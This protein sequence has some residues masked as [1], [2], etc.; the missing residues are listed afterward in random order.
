MKIWAVIGALMSVLA[1]APPEAGAEPEHAEGG[2]RPGEPSGYS[3]AGP[4]FYV[5]DEDR[6]EAEA[7]ALDLA[8]SWARAIAAAPPVKR[9]E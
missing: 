7:W 2:E 3:I 6:R 9:D 1:T 8:E 5:W 4:A